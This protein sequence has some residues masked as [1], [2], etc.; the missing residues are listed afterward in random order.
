MLYA[1]L[2]A[3]QK[4]AIETIYPAHTVPAPGKR[5]P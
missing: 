5:F 4:Q 2:S 3:P 1:Q